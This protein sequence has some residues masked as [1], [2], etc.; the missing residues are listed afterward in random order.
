MG[1]DR[2]L[3]LAEVAERLQIPLDTVYRWRSAGDG[4]PGFKLGRH[5]RVRASELDRWLDERRDR[6]PA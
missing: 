3:T 2:L 4:P 6:V 5:V 1:E